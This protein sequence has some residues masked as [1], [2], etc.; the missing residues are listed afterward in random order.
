VRLTPRGS[1][2][3][4]FLPFGYRFTLYLPLIIFHRSPEN[5]GQCEVS[6]YIYFLKNTHLISSQL[7]LASFSSVSHIC[8]ICLP[9]PS[10]P[11]RLCFENLPPPPPLPLHCFVR[12]CRGCWCRSTTRIKNLS[13]PS[14]LAPTENLKRSRQEE[15]EEEESTIYISTYT[16]VYRHIPEDE[17]EEEEE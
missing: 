1:H 9:P 14:L 17:E 4:R 12:R 8:P 6:C 10:P 13:L 15:E 5:P 11:P 7:F 3:K 2:S 16:A